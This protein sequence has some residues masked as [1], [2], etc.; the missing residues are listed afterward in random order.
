MTTTETEKVQI[1]NQ[2]MKVNQVT[3][4]ADFKGMVKNIS[5]AKTDAVLLLTFLDYRKELIG[6]KV[7]II[8][9]IE[10]GQLKKFNFK[11]KPHDGK[12][13]DSINFTISSDIAEMTEESK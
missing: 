5:D 13:V 10:P 12:I 6:D 8:R 4:E 7:V 2:D 9:D 11:Y 3:G 1:R